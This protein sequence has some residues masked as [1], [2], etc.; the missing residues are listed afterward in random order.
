V[1]NV[2]ECPIVGGSC[3]P[4]PYNVSGSGI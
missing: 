4:I 1:T 3:L 2:F